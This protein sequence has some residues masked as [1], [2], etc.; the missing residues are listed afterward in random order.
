MR[1]RLP[2]K[3]G[4]VLVWGRCGMVIALYGHGSFNEWT[5]EGKDGYEEIRDVW[6]WM[7]LPDPPVGA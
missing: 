2:E 1:S 4:Q 7:P 3:A 5:G 6:H